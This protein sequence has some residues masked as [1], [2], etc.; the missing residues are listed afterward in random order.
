MGRDVA[1][2]P[3]RGSLPVLQYCTPAQLAVD[4]CYQREL[5]GRSRQLIARIAAGWDWNLFQP[6]VVARRVDG[7]LYVVD[8]QHRLE[9]ARSRGD[10][11]Q[12]P[13]VVF[14]PGDP[15]DEAAVFVALNQ[16]RRPL[17]AY[18][19]FNAAL[20]A[21]DEEALRLDTLLRGAGLAFTGAAD[22]DRMKPGQ[23]NNVGTVRKWHARHGDRRTRIV[24]GA[25]GT[26]FRGQVIRI[27]SPL[28]MAT[29]AL[30]LERGEQLSA[31][32]LAD[33]LALPQN[34]WLAEFR[35]RAATDA[36]GIQAAAIACLREAYAEAIAEVEADAA[37]API[38]PEPPRGPADPR[39]STSSRLR[40]QWNNARRPGRLARR[41]VRG[42][43]HG[44]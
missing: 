29:A 21:G 11:Q 40:R 19:L 1:L 43:K 14:H 2:A 30:V 17:T 36:V 3:P 8:G 24:L 18:A 44:Q 25:I 20:A 10:I 12:L 9:A 28:F 6:L 23:I 39:R 35:R 42:A 4:P 33:V 32:L 37:P 31:H 34:E 22:P 16:E 26:A 7:T 41:R 15:A 38:A 27:A 13:C 5:D